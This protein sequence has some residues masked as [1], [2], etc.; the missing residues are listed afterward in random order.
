MIGVDLMCE[1]IVRGFE[2][3]VIRL[4]LIHGPD[5]IRRWQG[6][7][8]RPLGKTYNVRAPDEPENG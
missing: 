5:P 7:G 3:Y 4:E 2:G 6:L 8:S 1:V